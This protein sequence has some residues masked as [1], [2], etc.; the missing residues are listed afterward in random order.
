MWNWL[1]GA[2]GTKRMDALRMWVKHS[3]KRPAR[4][5]PETKETQKI[6]DERARLPI[7]NIPAH[8]V[9]KWGY[10]LR[11]KGD[12]RLIR[13]DE[14]VLRESVRRKMDLQKQWLRMIRW[15]FVGLDLE[16]LPEVKAEDCVLSL[17]K[18][19]RTQ[20]QAKIDAEEIMKSQ[21]EDRD[22]ADDSDDED[23][24]LDLEMLAEQMES[25]RA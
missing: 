25:E 16:T 1:R 21:Q 10:E 3:Y 7:M 17:M 20:A 24:L 14:L 18:R 23:P 11:G 12:K 8:M 2:D 22:M 15:G 5:G 4:P 9:G 19:K 6:L 13:P